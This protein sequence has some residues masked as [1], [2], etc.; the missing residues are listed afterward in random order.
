MKNININI[1]INHQGRDTVFPGTYTVVTR[2]LSGSS[3]M[4]PSPGPTRTTTDALNFPKRPCW[5]PGS[6]R[7]TPDVPGQTR[8]TTDLHG[9][10]T[11]HMPDHP[12]C[13]P[14]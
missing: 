5:H 8:T 13:D 14:C 7:I 11:V 3:R 12:R 9:S 10:Y 4:K 6:P 2:C 1:N